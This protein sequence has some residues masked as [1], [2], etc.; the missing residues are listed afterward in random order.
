MN[1]ENLT[2]IELIKENN[3]LLKQ[4]IE[5]EKELKDLRERE[6]IVIEERKKLNKVMAFIKS[7][8]KKYSDIVGIEALIDDET[9][10]V[11]LPVSSRTKRSLGMNNIKT[12]GELKKAYSCGNFL[13]YRNVGYVSMRQVGDLIQSVEHVKSVL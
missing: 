1:H 11:D 5:L 4:N 3:Q 8:Q 7:A 10:V 9:P 13:A 6:L 12:F 2:E